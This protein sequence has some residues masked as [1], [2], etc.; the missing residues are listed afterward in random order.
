M[1]NIAPLRKNIGS[2]MKFMTT[3]N[4]CIECIYAAATIPIEVSEIATKS[5]RGIRTMTV[6]I[7]ISTPMMGAKTSIR[8]P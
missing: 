7:P 1:G 4:P 5:I 3:V 2:I 8:Q 6:H